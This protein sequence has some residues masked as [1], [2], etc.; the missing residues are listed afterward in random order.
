LEEAGSVAGKMEAGWGMLGV[1]GARRLSAPARHDAEPAQASEEEGD[2]G[3]R[4]GRSA[5]AQPSR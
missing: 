5:A 1:R 3:G 4:A 2:G